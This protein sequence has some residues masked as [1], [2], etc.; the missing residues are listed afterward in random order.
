MKI[1]RLGVGPG[2]DLQWHPLVLM[3]AWLRVDGWYRSGNLAPEPELSR[4]RLHPERELRKLGDALRVGTWR[5]SRWA[6]IP[7]PKK[8]ECLR[9]YVLPTVRDQVAF[10]AYLVLLG[11]LLDS[12]IPNFVFGNRWNRRIA[13]DRRMSK[14]QWVL[15]PYQLLTSTAYLPYARSHGLF[16]RV[17][18]WT[19]ARMTG[20][21]IEEADYGGYV[22]HPDDYAASALPEWSRKE[23]WPARR[24]DRASVAW[25]TLD[26]E[27]AYPSIRLSRLRSALVTMLNM[28]SSD[29]ELKQLYGGYP[30]P[31]VKALANP[32]EVQRGVHLLMDALESVRIDPEAIP[33]KAWRPA[34]TLAE[35]PPKKEDHGLPT[36]LAISG[37]LLNVAMNQADRSVE[38]FLRE[39]RDGAMVRFADDIFVMAQSPHGLFD[40]IEAVWQGLAGDENARLATA[41]TESN[42]HLNW[43]KIEPPAVRKIIFSFLR[44]QG[45]SRCKQS[46]RCLHIW[47]PSTAGQPVALGAWWHDRRR[48]DS[49]AFTRMRDALKRCSVGP[50][51]V[52]PFVTTLVARMSE[53]GRDTLVERFGQGARERLIRLHDLARFDIDDLQV[54]SDTRRTFAANRLV[55]AWLPA[56]SARRDLVEIRESV[57]HV[58]RETP[59]KFSLWHAVVRTAARRPDALSSEDDRLAKDWLATQLGLVASV[60][61]DGLDS[62]LET[63]PEDTDTSEHHRDP[64][65]RELYLSFHRGAFWHAL[66]MA[67]R[68]LWWHVDEA[69]HPVAGYAGHSP[70]RW[71]VRAVQEGSHAHVRSWLGALDQWADVL[72]PADRTP[73]LTMWGWELD[74]LTAAALASVSRYDVAVAW[75]HA[76][77]PGSD[78]MVPAGPLWDGVPHIARV[79]ERNGRVSPHSKEHDLALATLAQVWLAGQDHRLGGF[80]FPRARPSRISDAQNDPGGTAAAGISLGCSKSISA[81]L[82]SALVH[83]SEHAVQAFGS[84][85]LA[86]WEYQRARRIL[87]GQPGGP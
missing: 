30:R 75:R 70:D 38:R 5:P 67:L 7:Y 6:Q 15:R 73:D 11:P 54:R 44:E 84:D 78:V 77:P 21:H 34:H 18:H 10:M 42:L 66:A 64:A 39:R 9:H 24:A 85:G 68:S 81:G 71:T 37:I 59:W 27:L 65:V 40:L 49:P 56:E 61:N 48:A 87:L 69:S 12:R 25:A 79:L 86:L 8:G 60:A 28:P 20:A 80:L 50:G 51:E 4:W 36:G 32:Q 17:A 33:E 31:I 14:P 72:Y 41:A 1:T 29:E 63:W 83:E 2:M 13:W 22:Q 46:E 43:S 53:I 74:Q 62:W 55:R 76:D 52:G 45:W 47:P 23:W 57:A 35:L 19:V 3:G 82:A 58:L 26:I 16:R